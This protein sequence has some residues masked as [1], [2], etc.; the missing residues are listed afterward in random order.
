[1]TEHRFRN[2]AQLTQSA[3][4]ELENLSPT[5]ANIVEVTRANA[6]LVER[7]EAIDQRFDAIDQRLENAEKVNLARSMNSSCTRGSAS[8]EWIK[9][10]NQRL[11]L[12]INTLLEFHNLN[13]D[14]ITQFLQYYNLET[15]KLDNIGNKSRLMNFLELFKRPKLESLNKI[16]KF[17]PRGHKNSQ[18]Q[19]L[20]VYSRYTTLKILYTTHPQKLIGKLYKRGCREIIT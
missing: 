5:L 10:D 12:Q 15:N 17:Y 2:L 8:I 1:M 19:L 16:I 4:T 13:N 9:K 20:T 3:A 7:F 11:P 14:Q 18:H 6:G